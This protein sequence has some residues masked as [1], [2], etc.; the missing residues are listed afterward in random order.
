MFIN[1]FAK[2][3]INRGVGGI[4]VGMDLLRILLFADDIV[5]FAEDAQGL[6]EMLDVLEKYARKWRFEV[7]VKQVKLWF[8]V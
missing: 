1:G 4:R 6:Q 8:V 3:L 2:E 7:N 5:L